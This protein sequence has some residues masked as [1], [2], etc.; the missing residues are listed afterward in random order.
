MHKYQLLLFICLLFLVSCKSGTEPGP[1]YNFFP[2]TV[3]SF[4]DYN[5]DAKYTQTVIGDTN[6]AGNTYAIVQQSNNDSI[7][8]YRK[9]GNTIYI[10]QR[11]TLN[12]MRDCKY[13]DPVPGASGGYATLTKGRTTLVTYTNLRQNF[14]DTVHGMIFPN[15]LLE[16][17]RYEILFPGTNSLVSEADYYFA[18][19]VGLIDEVGSFSTE[20]L[21]N[22]KIK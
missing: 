1:N 2:L 7:Y 16:H 3:G 15:V 20:E 13:V 5:G 6:V 21:I 18:D 14:T 10:L 8:Y 9:D 19:G 22:F 11:D 17:I 12:I 4:W